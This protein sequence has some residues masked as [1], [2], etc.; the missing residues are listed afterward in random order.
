M[1]LILQ[2]VIVTGCLAW[3]LAYLLERAGLLALCGW[4]RRRPPACAC[5]YR[6]PLAKQ[7]QRRLE[8]LPADENG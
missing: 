8:Q 1:N 3:A 7:A 2:W 6:C 5:G 4:T